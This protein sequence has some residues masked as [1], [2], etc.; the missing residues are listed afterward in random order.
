MTT[1]LH[2]VAGARLAGG[3]LVCVTPDL[4]MR[5][6]MGADAGR[7][8]LAELAGA[9]TGGAVAEVVARVP[10]DVDRGA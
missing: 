2:L 3:A 6:W 4:A 9:L 8:L 1:Q 7:T 10:G 5:A